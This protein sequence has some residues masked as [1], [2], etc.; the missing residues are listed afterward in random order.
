MLTISERVTLEIEGG[1]LLKE[2][3]LT[4]LSPSCVTATIGG[5]AGGEIKVGGGVIL[6]NSPETIPH[7]DHVFFTV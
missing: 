2:E 1:V 6:F 7:N 5:R 4:R 3:S